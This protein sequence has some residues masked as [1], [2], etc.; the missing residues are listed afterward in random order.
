[1][2]SYGGR[3]LWLAAGQDD[4][5]A[6]DTAAALA[7]AASGEVQLLEVSAGRGVELLQIKPDL[8]EELASWMRRRL[9]AR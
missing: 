3:P 8:V 5:E 1:M 2:P 6:M 4:S 9:Q 7:E